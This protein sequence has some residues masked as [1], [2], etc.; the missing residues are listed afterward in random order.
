MGRGNAGDEMRHYATVVSHEYLPHLKV[1]FASMQRHCR[2]FKLH[3]YCWDAETRAWCDSADQ[4][5]MQGH[6]SMAEGLS[7]ATPGLSRT[8]AETIWTLRSAWSEIVSRKNDLPVVQVDADL[9]F[10]SSPEPLFAEVGSAKLGVISHNFGHG[11]T[12]G[13]TVKTHGRYGTFNAG[14]VV[15][16]DPSVAWRWSEMTRWW[17]YDHVQT[18]RDVRERKTLSGREAEFVEMFD[19]KQ[20]YSDQVYLDYLFDEFDGHFVEHPGAMVAPWNIHRSPLSQDADGNPLVAGQ[21][22]ITYHYHSMKLDPVMPVI[23]KPAND[24]Y[25]LTDEHVRLFYLP[26]LEELRRQT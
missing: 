22:V 7:F 1:L 15:I 21:R 9:M 23:L 16:N 25:E 13:P 6:G 8:K 3:V 18:M 11:D 26:Y 10:F 14:M 12:P 17:C 5:E 24:E 19:G 20:L 4:S 2:P